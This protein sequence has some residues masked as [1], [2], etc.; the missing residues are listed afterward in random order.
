MIQ[1]FNW[2]WEA[3]VRVA[4]G[5][6]QMLNGLSTLTMKLRRQETVREKVRQRA[7]CTKKQVLSTEAVKWR[8][9]LR[10]SVGEARG[11]TR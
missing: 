5:E 1:V 8:A 7:G 2:A 11:F 3:A 10:V 9:V 6:A 4:G